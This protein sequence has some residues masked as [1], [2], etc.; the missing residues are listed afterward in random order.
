MKFSAF[1]HQCMARA[2]RLARKGWYTAD[3][4]PRVG[5]VIARD[6]KVVGE[7]Y[8]RRAGEAHAEVNALAQ[9]GE[10]ARGAT[11]YV[12]LEPCNHRGRTGPCSGALIDAGV[13]EVVYGMADAHRAA[14]GGIGTL[15]A[16]GI[17]VRGPLLESESARLNPGF[18]RRCETGRPLVTLKLAM[19]LDGRTAMASGESRWVTGEPARRDVQL[20]RAESSAVVT[21]IGT[22][23]GDDPAMNV[24]EGSLPLANAAEV[25]ARQPLRVIVDGRLR[26]P[27]AAKMLHLGGD[28]L[29]ATGVEAAAFRNDYPQRVVQVSL[30]AG[31]GRVDLAALLDVL[32]RRECNG[33]L[34]EAGPELGGAF[35]RA[36]LVDRLVVYMAGKLMGSGGRPLMQL[37]LETMA[38][39]VNLKIEEIRAVGDD[40]RIIATPQD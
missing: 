34:V 4:N 3:P 11:V 16:A 36:G 19:S 7:G 1:D 33:V 14:A 8:H 17:T 25:A 32:G 27:P 28:I 21:G 9:A 35:M 40:W 20:L 30:P 38:E 5:C 10:A 37:P 2:I 31:D 6:G 29:I 24:R 18:I 15:A 22:V 12:T 23:L 26:T 13:G 39:A